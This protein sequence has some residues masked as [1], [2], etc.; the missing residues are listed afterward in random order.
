MARSWQTAAFAALAVL[1]CRSACA[2]QLPA[3]PAGGGAAAPPAA[4]PA[5]A[6]VAPPALGGLRP[7]GPI[8]PP[9]RGPSLE[10]A[11]EAAQAALALC[12][13]QGHDIGVVVAD[14][15]GATRVALFADTKNPQLIVF[16]NGKIAA[17]LAFKMNS[18]D[19][20]ERAKTDK[21]VAERLAANSGTMAVPGAVLLKSGGEIV[22][23]IGGTGATS[24]ED[25]ACAQAGADRISARL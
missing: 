15:A 8:P 23:A 20:R 5:G 6:P 22:G 14:S 25:A 7:G 24:E 4:T 11:L 2:Q 13:A 3:P 12:H 1:L 16:A 9:A 19:I 21:A 17:A 10:L 18:A